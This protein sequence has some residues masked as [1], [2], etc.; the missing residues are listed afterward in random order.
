MPE[1]LRPGV[2]VEERPAPETIEGVST[3]TVGLVG[4]SRFLAEPDSASG[5]R[6][7]GAAF[8]WWDVLGD[9]VSE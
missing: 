3:S 6:G 1:Y 4:A 2:Y 9:R 5:E 7:E 8:G